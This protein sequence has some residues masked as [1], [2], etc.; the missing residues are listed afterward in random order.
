MTPPVHTA[1]EPVELLPC[2]FCGEAVHIRK[3]VNGYGHCKTD[4]CHAS[5]AQI[6]SLDDQ[7][8][9]A[10][11]NRRALTAAPVREEGGA[12]GGWIRW[13]GGDNPV[14][15]LAVE[16]R[17]RSGDEF[18][19]SDLSDNATWK[20]IWG[21]GDI[22]A[23]RLAPREEAPGTDAHPFVQSHSVAL[24]GCCKVCGQTKDAHQEALAEAGEANL[25]CFSALA[26]KHGYHTQAD[27]LAALRAQPQARSGEGQ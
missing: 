10:A 27:G 17:L 4:G 1:S 11:W 14:P 16:I 2:P 5:R 7:K 8:Q 25:G 21:E 18:T 3:G 9:V 24:E 13:D 22:I 15:G 26:R 6:V 19:G 20:H 23:Y 12:V